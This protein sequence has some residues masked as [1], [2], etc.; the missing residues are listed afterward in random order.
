[1]FQ[2][3]IRKEMQ[4]IFQTAGSWAMIHWSFLRIFLV[5]YWYLWFCTTVS[6]VAELLDV[7][8]GN[9]RSSNVRRSRTQR[10]SEWDT[11]HTFWL[12]TLYGI[13]LHSALLLRA[14]IGLTKVCTDCS[15]PSETFLSTE[16]LLNYFS[17]SIFLARLKVKLSGHIYDDC[18]QIL[19][20]EGPEVTLIFSVLANERVKIK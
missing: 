8:W 17:E 18:R 20:R 16:K 9:F 13:L 10:S 4:P 19:V 3:F 11:S 6:W 14:S 7:H 12:N 2:H 5:W 1:M 15:V